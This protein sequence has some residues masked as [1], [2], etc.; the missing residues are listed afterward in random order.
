MS[1]RGTKLLPAGLWLKL[2]RFAL[3]A[4]LMGWLD[5]LTAGPDALPASYGSHDR[6]PRGV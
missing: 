2:F 1:A 5:G 3:V 6:N 4:W